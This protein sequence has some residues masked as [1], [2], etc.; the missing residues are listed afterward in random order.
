MTE[1]TE[2]ILG[3]VLSMNPEDRAMIAH[4]LISSLEQ[5]AADNTDG[6][7]L[8]LAETR[9]AEL[10]NKIFHF[11]DKIDSLPK[12][13]DRILP[14]IHIRIKPTTFCNHNCFYCAYRVSNQKLGK[15]MNINDLIPKDKMMEI[16]DD[17]DGLYQQSGGASG[18][19]KRVSVLFFL[20]QNGK[21]HR[22]CSRTALLLSS[23]LL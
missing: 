10:E 18:R 20:W 1:K 6:E 5:A 13:V 19:R 11:Q 21:A 3:E 23:E 9:L 16:I 7:W 8:K 15:D 12:T 22:N 4:C 17:L 2:V 14:P